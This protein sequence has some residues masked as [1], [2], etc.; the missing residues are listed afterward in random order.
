[1]VA[2]P[3]V[4]QKAQDEL[5]TITGTRFPAL[6][7]IQSLPYVRATIQEVSAVACNKYCPLTRIQG[8]TH[9]PATAVF[10]GTFEHRGFMREFI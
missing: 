10:S 3:E 2:Y 7:D 9:V 5:D 1:M 8:S 4:Q 6:E